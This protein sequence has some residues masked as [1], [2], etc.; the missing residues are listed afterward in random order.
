MIVA[1]TYVSMNEETQKKKETCINTDKIYN[2]VYI[3]DV[4]ENKK[5]QKPEKKANG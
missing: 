2:T 5:E 1:Y 3:D 4:E